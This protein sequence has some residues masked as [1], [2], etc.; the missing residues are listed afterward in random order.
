[1][2]KRRIIRGLEVFKITGQRL[3]HLQTQF[4]EGRPASAVKVFALS[5]PREE[6]HRRIDARVEQMF[7]SG[8]VEEVRQLLVKYGSLSRTAMQAVGYREVI[9]YLQSRDPSSRE[10]AT[11]DRGQETAVRWD[12]R[13][14]GAP[15]AIPDSRPPIPDSLAS[16][17]H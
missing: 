14:A 3:S 17:P 6:L 16:C 15:P 8:L 5:W 1:N 2:D 10:P 9:E 12:Q 4:D 13:S 7:A 11:G